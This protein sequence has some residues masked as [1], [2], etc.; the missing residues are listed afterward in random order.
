MRLQHVEKLENSRGKSEKRQYP[1]GDVN[2]EYALLRERQP[3]QEPAR[4]ERAHKHSRTRVTHINVIFIYISTGAPGSLRQHTEE[5]ELARVAVQADLSKDGAFSR[6]LQ[7]RRMIRKMPKLRD[8][9]NADTYNN[10]LRAA[11]LPPLKS[12]HGSEMWSGCANESALAG[13]KETRET[14][15]ETEDRDTRR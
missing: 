9:S 8:S 14:G 13:K 1:E 15:H 3:L 2:T 12:A 11:A 4:E 6:A 5:E 10:C 7:G